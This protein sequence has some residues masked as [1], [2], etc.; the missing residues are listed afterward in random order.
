MWPFRVFLNKRKMIFVSVHLRRSLS[1]CCRNSEPTRKLPI[2]VSHR[3]NTMIWSMIRVYWMMFVCVLTIWF[4]SYRRTSIKRVNHR[5]L[6]RCHFLIYPWSRHRQQHR[7]AR[8]PTHPQLLTRCFIVPCHVSRRQRAIKNIHS[9]MNISYVF[10]LLRSRVVP[11]IWQVQPRQRILAFSER[12]VARTNPNRNSPTNLYSTRTTV[13]IGATQCKTLSIVRHIL[14]SSIR[15]FYRMTI[16]TFS[17]LMTRLPMISVIWRE[18]LIGKKDCCCCCCCFLTI[19]NSSR[20]THSFVFFL[21]FRRTEKLLHE[22]VSLSLVLSIFPHMTKDEINIC[23]AYA[24][25]FLLFFYEWFF[26]SIR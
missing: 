5:P 9:V 8:C 23:R 14:P 6:Y 18:V 1:R 26:S 15:F 11:I 13:T 17:S 19:E 7:R 3:G 2:R 10:P 21:F 24:F 22:C 25:G 4:F 16:R 20:M 12:S